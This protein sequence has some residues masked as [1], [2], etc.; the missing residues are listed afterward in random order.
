[1]LEGIHHVH[2][3]GIGGAG[4]SGIAK[5]LCEL[6][7]RVSGSDLHASETTRRLTDLGADIFIGHRR[8]QIGDAQVV[9]V[10]TAIPANNEELSEA[11]ERGM[12]IWPRAK[13]LSAIMSRQKGIAIAGA[14]GKTTTTSMIAMIM[15]RNGLDPSVVVGGELNDIGGNAKLGKGTYLVAEADES[16]GSFLNLDPQILVVTNIEDDHLD[17]YGSLENILAA[18]RDMMEKVPADG[19]AVV[20]A[21]DENIHR[22]KESLTCQVL[23]YGVHP[24]A[25]FQ[26]ANIRWKHLGSTYDLLFRGKTLGTVHLTVPGLHNV[27]NSMA[28]LAVCLQA[29]I[30]FTAAVAALEV[31]HGVHR[32]FQLMGD[33]AGI[34]VF[35]DYAHHPSEVKATLS[36]ARLEHPGRVI[37]IFQ[38]HRFTRTKFLQHEFGRAFS[39]ADRVILTDIYSAGEPPIE[40]IHTRLL[41]KHIQASG[42]ESVR[43]IQ[44]MKEIAEILAGELEAGD[45]VLTLGAGNIW[46]VGPALVAKLKNAK[47]ESTH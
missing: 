36:A 30:E 27:K 39:D 40:G 14:H 9:V 5:V 15:E 16:D 35:D 3:I 44:D 1:M 17:Y 10:S 31:F 7:Y 43:Y 2:F 25:D 18:F 29:G 24:E 8:G 46:Q 6:G 34:Q 23:T 45:L 13:M 26:P 22:I 12:D 20:C 32:R 37:A 47:E 4:M 11:R 28:A 38:P 33:V 21:D 41:E 42:H 19:L